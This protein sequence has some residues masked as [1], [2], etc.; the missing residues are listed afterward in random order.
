MKLLG[1]LSP[2]KNST[3]SLDLLNLYIVNQISCKKKAPEIV[4]KPIHVNMNRDIKMPL[5]QFELELPMSP[6]YIPSK[7]CLDDTENNNIHCQELGNKEGCG[8]VQ[9][10]QIMDSYSVFEPQFG[11]TENCS[12]TP[13]SFSTELS[14]DRHIPKQNFTPTAV[15]CPLKVA[16]GKKQND[17]LN[18]V[19]CSD[20]LISKL[21]ECQDG[22]NSPYEV[23]K[24]GAL[25]E[26]L[27]NPGNGNFLTTRPGISLDED[28]K[29]TNERQADLIFGKQAA[30][31]IWGENGKEISDFLKDVNQPTPSILPENGGS[32]VGPNMIDL[33]SIDQ[34]MMQKT[35]DKRGCDSLG[36]ACLVVNSDENHS[37]D[38]RVR[39]SFT[40]P[41]ST[42]SDS[43]FHKTSGPEKCQP[44]KS[45]QKEHNSNEIR[46]LSIVFEDCYPASYEKQGKNKNDY[47]EKMPQKNNQED[48]VNSVCT[49]PLEELHPT[50][51]GPFGLAEIMKEGTCSLKGG[52]V[53][54]KICQDLDSSQGSQCSS[55]SPRPTESCFSSS[56]EMPSED[57]DQ[58]L[59]QT[60]DSHKI[61]TQTTETSND[62]YLERTVEL[63]D[64]RIVSNNATFH[65][66]N[67]KFYQHSIKNNADQFPQS[68][69]NLAHAVE[70]KTSSC[71]VQVVKRDTGVQ[72]ETEAA[73]EGKSDAA[74]QCDIRSA[75]ACGR[76]VSSPRSVERCAQSIA[77]DTT[78]GQGILTDS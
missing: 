71:I 26:E 28:W 48:P 73:T 8:P 51:A 21:S 30:Q 53:S 15:P 37:T 68:Q 32:F 24:F 67:E 34:Q 7:L 19:K 29:S 43:A 11:R 52:P 47:Q 16:F 50:Q 5:R 3:V 62:F 1:A 70:N 9:S 42:F 40:V 27:N 69:C 64:N 65:N 77:A 39:S 10:S 33:L 72:T 54:K 14:P 18:N 6:Q 74:V 25:F 22:L 17:Q 58:I 56:S 66:Q 59:Q 46:D 36:K 38:L 60:G 20:S 78:G 35:F 41:E 76:A 55:Y 12:F 31:P 75:C 61:S 23:A 44:V 13:P 2:V 4:K 57:E 63:S 49:S 45:Y